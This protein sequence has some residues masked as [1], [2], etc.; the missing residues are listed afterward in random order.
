VEEQTAPLELKL[1]ECDLKISKKIV[2]DGKLVTKPDFSPFCD[3]SKTAIYTLEDGEHFMRENVY[4][5]KLGYYIA[6]VYS[7]KQVKI[8]SFVN[9]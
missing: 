4:N 7:D 3:T 5:P 6:I 9:G 8:L 1:I 2:Q